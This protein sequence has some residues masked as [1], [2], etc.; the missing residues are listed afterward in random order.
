MTTCFPRLSAFRRL[1][2]T[3][4]LVALPGVGLVGCNG[5]GSGTRS[6]YDAAIVENDELRDR[7]AT[8]QES[9]RSANDQT[10]SAQQ[11]IDEL[12]R[13]N[14]QLREQA[15]GAMQAA[16]AASARPVVRQPAAPTVINLAGD[17][18][19]ASGSATLREAAKAQLAAVARRLNGE[20][21]GRTIRVEGYSDTQPLNKSRAVWLSNEHLSM[22][23]A[24]AVESYLV[25][26]GV[27]NDRIYSA[28][29]GPTNAKPTNAASRRVE[30]VIL[31]AGS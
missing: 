8:L 29:F 12:E 11:S 9:V 7:I 17:G 14:S 15:A 2:L 1:T 4:L 20:F 19:F 16:E 13:E 10:A 3:T 6:E 5:S 26:R 18:L 31:P 21:A 24:L 30:I 25:E 28:G 23:R 22:M 27:D